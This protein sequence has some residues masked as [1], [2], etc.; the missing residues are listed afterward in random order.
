MIEFLATR[1]RRPHATL[2]LAHGSGVRM[3]APFMTYISEALAAH[4]VS[5][6]RF[7]FT[8]M[9]GR[10]SGH[11]N[12]PEL[13]REFVEALSAVRSD[14]PVFIGGKSMGGRVASMIAEDAYQ[15]GRIAGVI[16]LGYPFHAPSRPDLLRTAH[17]VTTT[18]PTLI[19]Q[20]AQD[21]FGTRKQVRGYDLS[22]AVEFF[23]LE[24]CD[25]DFKPGKLSD[26][27][28]QENIE[29]AANAVAQWTDD[30]FKT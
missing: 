20:G 12:P 22:D 10:T 4:G 28:Q 7:E 6:L 26:Q 1:S 16:C 17:L 14:E 15:H 21:P 13:S 29:R 25:H 11:H 8:Y 19:C 2:V 3:N 18:V 27:T 24:G 5:V 9:T 23:W 30:H